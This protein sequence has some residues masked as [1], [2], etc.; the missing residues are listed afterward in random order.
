MKSLGTYAEAAVKHGEPSEGVKA[1][2][3][4]I[5]RLEGLA[6]AAAVHDWERIRAAAAEFSNTR[7]RLHFVRHGRTLYN[8]ANRVSGIH[9]TR[10]SASGRRQAADLALRL[11]APMSLVLSSDL[12]RAYETAI[13]YCETTGIRTPIVQDRRLREVDL[14]VLAGKKRAFVQPYAAGDVDFAPDGGESYRAA[15]RRTAS[16]LI[17]VASVLRDER[18]GCHIAVFT[19]TGTMRI[20]HSFFNPIGSG[21]QVFGRKFRNIETFSAEIGD[22]RLPELWVDAAA[23]TRRNGLHQQEPADCGRNPGYRF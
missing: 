20:V 4:T 13:I 15:S 6:K 22:F 9:D 8:G 23:E 16:W 21:R 12:V 5:T 17:D 2:S 1:R 10:L 19:H 7:A 11:T 14:G 3:E 18:P